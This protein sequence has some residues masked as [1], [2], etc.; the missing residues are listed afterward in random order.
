MTISLKRPSVSRLPKTN[1]GTTWSWLSALGAD[2]PETAK[3][4][5]YNYI[6]PTRT[7][8]AVDG[9]SSE[10]LAERDAASFCIKYG[11]E[12]NRI[13]RALV[14]ECSPHAVTLR[15][16]AELLRPPVV[17]ANDNA[18]ADADENPG[19]GFERV[20]GHGCIQPSIP[21]L[22][23][24]HEAGLK[25]GSRT[26]KDG[27]HRIGTSPVRGEL[28]GLTFM[29]GELVEYGDNKGRK[30]RPSY[31]PKIAEEDVDPKSITARH[32]AAQAVED[33][34]YTRL[35]GASVYVSAQSPNAPRSLA[36]AVRTA[37]AVAND[38]MLAKAIANTPVMPPVTRLPDGVA[39]EYGRLAGIADLTGVGD[40]KTSAPMND[41]LTEMERA[42]FLAASG[43]EADDLDIIEA[44][45][46]DASFRT[47]GMQ[48]G[49]AESAAHRMGRKVVEGAL[50][51]ISEKIAA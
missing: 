18:P 28:T 44:I 41:A 10:W 21:M 34:S 30:R 49:Y 29:N 36:S 9:P 38:N 32:R 7:S 16:V 6:K 47:I 20:H 19:S 27:W 50:T 26:V 4:R 11:S 2:M 37:R 15:L 42:E 24:A 43:I 31:N 17:A 22:L 5:R 39:A 23:R 8:A 14:K 33:V 48:R 40:G 3:V 35:R 46:S 13:E 25:T 1:D 51:R 12:G 45:L